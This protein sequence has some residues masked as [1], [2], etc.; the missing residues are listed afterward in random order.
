MIKGTRDTNTLSKGRRLG[1]GSYGAV[2][3]GMNS[4]GEFAVKRNIVEGN[5]SFTRC[6]READILSLLNGHP[7]IVPLADIKVKE[8]FAVP[9]SPLA[10]ATDRDD[11]IHFVFEK[12]ECDLSK[13][14]HNATKYPNH[15]Y[16]PMIKNM[17]VDILLGMEFIH[18]NGII[19]QDLKIDNV[20]YYPDKLNE[21]GEKGVSVI[22]DMGLSA[23]HSKQLVGDHGVYSKLIKA[24][25]LFYN[26]N[27]DYSIDVW[28]LGCLFVGLYNRDNGILNDLTLS[29]KE[30]EENSIRRVMTKIINTIPITNEEFRT[31]LKVHDNKL[32]Y[33]KKKRTWSTV[34]KPNNDFDGNLPLFHALVGGMLNV[35]KRKRLTVTQCLDH[36]F[37]DEKT[38][39]RITA[40]RNKYK[41]DAKIEPLQIVYC[42]EREWFCSYLMDIFLFPS[43][44]EGFNDRIAFHILRLFDTYMYSIK[45]ET[46]YDEE[47]KDYGHYLTKETVELCFWSLLNM[48]LKYF[49]VLD[50]V[51]SWEQLTPEK[52]HSEDYIE[53]IQDFENSILHGVGY[54]FYKRSMYEEMDNY[55]DDNPDTQQRFVIN[56]MMMYCFNKTLNGIRADKLVEHV[57]TTLDPE[58]I[59]LL[60]QRVML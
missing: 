33:P 38:K 2:Y 45:D 20:L 15:V 31:C 7:H 18:Q 16:Y 10:R 56:V 57:Y 54:G 14:A 37:W 21:A 55:I 13:I 17:M 34:L 36:D 60:M 28:A 26:R 50:T 49:F 9:M 3:I 53:M 43:K 46:N 24:P 29:D 30:C 27:F 5:V 48:C 59:G 47:T 6:I 23:F 32:I 19:H 12:A 41:P 51:P 22:C 58:N 1:G 40:T 44:I 25:E 42:I 8:P 39:E 11:S 52:F 35:D 4:S